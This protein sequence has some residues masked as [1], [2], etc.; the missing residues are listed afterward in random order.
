MDANVYQ[1]FRSEERPFIDTVED[2]IE[3]VNMQYAPVLTE[4]LDPRQAFILET[5]VRQESELKFRFFGGYEEA[6]RSR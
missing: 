4:F 2:W 3:Q 5:L 1:H 6:E